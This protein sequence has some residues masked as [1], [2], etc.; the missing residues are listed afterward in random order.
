MESRFFAFTPRTLLRVTGDDRQSVLNNFF[1]NE[2]MDLDSGSG[3]EGFFPNEKGKINGH[4]FLFRDED[5]FWVET[6]GRQGQ[7]ISELI[8]RFVITEDIEF[9]NAFD[10]DQA[11]VI[12][13]PEMDEPNPRFELTELGDQASRCFFG[14]SDSP[15]FA[16]Y[17][18]D[19]A[20]LEDIA[21]QLA[22]RGYE[23]IS[24]DS[25][26]S[27]RIRNGMLKFGVDYSSD[28]LPQELDRDARTI[29]FTKGCYLGQET[30]ARLDALG[31]VN[32]VIRP[33]EFDA[34]NSVELPLDL[35][36]ESKRV[37]RLTSFDSGTKHGI[38]SVR[39]PHHKPGSE[40]QLPQGNLVV[41]R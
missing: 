1:S 35:I 25:F 26:E 14:I 7:A 3:C 32:Q 15:H 38:A 19:K 28:N 30:I 36:N 29:S 34:A 10:A 24:G 11:I 16:G 31:H 33:V 4:G 23:K 40:I 9:A 13:D 39:V 18:A 6:E 17:H 5:C 21:G 12:F 27:F 20:V 22:N 8:S 2:M 37:A 41:A